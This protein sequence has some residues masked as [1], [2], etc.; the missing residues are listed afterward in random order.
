MLTAKCDAE[1]NVPC[2]P[3]TGPSQLQN[4]SEN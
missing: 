2:F 4:L 1:G 3:S